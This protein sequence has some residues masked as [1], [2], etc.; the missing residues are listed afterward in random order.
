LTQSGDT[1]LFYVEEPVSAIVAVGKALSATRPTRTKWYEAKVGAI[2]KLESPICLKEFR[3]MFSDWAWLKNVSMFAYVSPERAKAL[4][5]RCRQDSKIQTDNM[6]CRAGA[7]F[8]N[9]DELIIIHDQPRTPTQVLR[10][11]L[12]A[13]WRLF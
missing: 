3:Q 10:V 2:R 8:G 7:G 12:S 13:G 9:A 1:V 11:T 5:K 4:L 6:A